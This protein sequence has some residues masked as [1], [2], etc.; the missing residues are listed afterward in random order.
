MICPEASPPGVFGTFV[1]TKV[2]KG[3][4]AKLIFNSS[5]VICAQI[6]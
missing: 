4:R 5:R 1:G 3:M 6:Y 2:Q